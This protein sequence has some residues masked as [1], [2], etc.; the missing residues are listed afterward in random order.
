MSLIEYKSEDEFI[1]DCGPCEYCVHESQFC[2]ED[3]K[4]F[5]P[6]QREGDCVGESCMDCAHEDDCADD[7]TFES[8]ELDCDLDCNEC[9]F[10]MC[11]HTEVD[12]EMEEALQEEAEN[13][14][15]DLQ[16]A[17]EAVKEDNDKYHR[18]E[19]LKSRYPN[20]RFI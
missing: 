3:G 2:K 5:E 8:K 17:E 15:S 7:D 16:K 13:Y 18:T 19:Q 10:D 9:S 1:T 4:E 20:K 14:I 12:E 11:I 6:M